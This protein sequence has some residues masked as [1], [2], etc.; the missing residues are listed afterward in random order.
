VTS[1]ID[2][3]SALLDA[4]GCRRSP[5]YGGHSDGDFYRAILDRDASFYLDLSGRLAEWLVAADIGMVASDAVEGY[6]PTHD[7]CAAVTGR[8]VRLA[9]AR[10]ERPVA[11]FTFLLTGAPGARPPVD[12]LELELGTAALADKLAEARR[13]AALAGGILVDEVDDMIA[14]Y[15]E[16][17]FAREFLVPACLDDDFAA[18]ASAAPFY[19]THGEKQVAAGLYQ[20]VIR[21]RQHVAPIIHALAA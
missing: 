17:S 20:Q 2:L 15:G 8:A 18:F 3:T 16:A 12:A 7:L 6:N 1:R 14:R 11:H 19:E 10:G 9:A 21:Y 13:Y 5:V 4:A